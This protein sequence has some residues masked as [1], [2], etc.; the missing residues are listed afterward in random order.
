MSKNFTGKNNNRNNST[1]P[2]TMLISSNSN[3][4]VEDVSGWKRHYHFEDQFMDLNISNTEIF[5]F[6]YGTWKFLY[7]ACAK[8]KKHI[9]VNSFS[10]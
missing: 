1:T 2:D 5:T 8:L 3:R 9:R 4:N 10:W 7:S 6:A